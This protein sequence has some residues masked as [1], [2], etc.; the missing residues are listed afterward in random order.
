[1][2]LYRTSAVSRLSK[3]QAELDE[4]LGCEVWRVEAAPG[5]L[6]KTREML[7]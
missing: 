5:V 1:M 3:A 4:R 7:S 6:V 2:S